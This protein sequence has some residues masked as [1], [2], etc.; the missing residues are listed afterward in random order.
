M[1]DQFDELEKEILETMKKI[2]SETVIDHAMNPRNTE[3]ISCPD[4]LGSATSGCGE[5]MEIRLRAKDGKITDSS[6]WTDGCSTTVACGSMA[7]ELIKDK[8][9]SHAMV[10]SQSEIIQA[11]GGLPEGNKHCA[12]LAANTVKAAALDYMSIKKEPWKKAYRK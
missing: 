5:I 9:V 6:F 3:Q 2:Y 11:L 4:G 8:D 10:I 7:S 12:L 1:P